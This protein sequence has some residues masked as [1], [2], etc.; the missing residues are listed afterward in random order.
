MKIDNK[1]GNVLFQRNDLCSVYASLHPRNEYT[2][3]HFNIKKLR[4]FIGRHDYETGEELLQAVLKVF[5]K[6]LKED[7]YL[8][9][10][11]RD[12]FLFLIHEWRKKELINFLMRMDYAGYEL[13]DVRFFNKVFFSIGVCRFRDFPDA[14]FETCCFYADLA[15][16]TSNEREKKSSDYKIFTK[17]ALQRFQ[18]RSLLEVKTVEA[19]RK[20]TYAIYIQPKVEAKTQKICG[21]EALLRWF[22]EAGNEIPLTAFLPVLNE[23][24]YIRY[25]DQM[26]FELVCGMIQDSLQKGMNMVPI[27]FNLSKASFEDAPF[28]REY[29]EL[30]KKFDI[31]KEYIEFELLESISMDHSGKLLEVVETIHEAGFRCALDDFGSGY[32]SMS[33]LVSAPLDIIKLDR[34][35]FQLRYDGMENYAIVDGLLDILHHFPVKIIAEGVEDAAMAEHLRQK[36]CDMIQGFYYYRP[37]P[38]HTF[39][40]LIAE[41]E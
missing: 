5:I 18:Q 1:N 3:L 8:L 19:C 27:S 38:M 34:S 41:Q 23:N 7:Q 21:G 9:Y 6:E 10:E 20:E 26:V 28:M 24:S 11:G 39:Q 37:M 12:D 40:K 13:E 33:V 17:K 4:Y 14:D 15:R 22:D 30:F 35:L 32:S 16:L 29:M 25:V 36:G 2:L 31:P